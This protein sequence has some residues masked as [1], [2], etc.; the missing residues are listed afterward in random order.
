M[1]LSGRDWDVSP[2]ICGHNFCCGVTSMRI[3]FFITLFIS[4]AGPLSAQ[5]L[6]INEFFRDA[7]LDGASN[8]FI[9]LVITQPMTATELDSY[10][11]GDSDDTRSFKGVIMQFQNMAGLLTAANTT[12]SYYPQGTI[13]VVGGTGSFAEDITSYQPEIGNYTIL[14][15]SNN[16]TYISKSFGGV[17]GENDISNKDVIWVDNVNLGPSSISNDG[18]GVAFGGGPAGLLE[19][20]SSVTNIGTPGDGQE[21]GNSSD[22][23]GAILGDNWLINTGETIG[24]CNGLPTSENCIWLNGLQDPDVLAVTLSSVDLS[25]DPAGNLVVVWETSDEV[26][27][28]GFH[29]H[30][31]WTTDA[32]K[33]LPETQVTQSLIP[34]EDPN[35]SGAVYTYTIPA[36]EIESYDPVVIFIEDIEFDGKNTFNGPY[37]INQVRTNLQDWL[38]YH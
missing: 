34:S 1:Q 15:N 8:E 22:D 5:K 14:L 6:I 13:L 12:L 18:F 21:I 30:T 29:L 37:M 35:G 38:L 20:S 24:A 32:G 28:A 33:P 25:F 23:V 11:V 26:N 16:G 36:E 19:S 17:T 2:Y 27:N 9:E 10:S 3:P 4:V 31:G 7:T